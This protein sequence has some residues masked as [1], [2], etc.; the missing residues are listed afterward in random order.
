[1]AFEGMDPE[2]VM[3]LAAQLNNQ[4][5]NIQSIVHQIDSI[6]SQLEGAWKGADASQFQEWWTSQHKPALLAAASAVGGLG[7]SA[8]N[9]AQAQIETS[10]H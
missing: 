8:H 6:V 7:Q 5:N 4:D 3:G 10:S 2:V 9:N 1:M